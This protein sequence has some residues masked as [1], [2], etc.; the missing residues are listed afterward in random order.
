MLS[1]MFNGA[2]GNMLS[3]S[4]P[5]TPATA[6]PPAPVSPANSNRSS[7]ASPVRLQ[8]QTNSAQRHS[9]GRPATLAPPSRADTPKQSNGSDADRRAAISPSA[10]TD[11]GMLLSPAARFRPDAELIAGSGLAWSA[12]PNDALLDAYAAHLWRLVQSAQAHGRERHGRQARRKQM[13]ELCR[14]VRTFQLPDLRVICDLLSALLAPAN[15]DERSSGVGGGSDEQH[16]CMELLC[17]CLEHQASARACRPFFFH[18]L[19]QSRNSLPSRLHGISLLTRNGRECAPFAVSAGVETSE[20]AAQF[21][22]IH[23][24]Q[25]WPCGACT[26]SHE[27]PSPRI[28]PYVVTP[29]R[30]PSC[31]FLQSSMAA[32]LGQWVQELESIHTQATAHS[33]AVAAASN[34]SSPSSA[35]A[36]AAAAV[37]SFHLSA[38][39]ASVLALPP[40]AADSSV[41]SFLQLE[42]HDPP[43]AVHRATTSKLLLLLMRFV[44]YNRGSMG[45][46]NFSNLV[47]RVSEKAAAESDQVVQS[48]LLPF[49][50]IAI[51]AGL[52][53]TVRPRVVHALCLCE[54]S[55]VARRTLAA[56]RIRCAP[57]L[58]RNAPPPH[59]FHSFCA[60]ACL[61]FVQV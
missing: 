23:E 53:P 41:L 4:K 42:A 8:S 38:A 28:A 13:D 50:D 46:A 27:P 17:L 61:L 37:S 39:G 31:L 33:A 59:Y 19:T 32:V 14:L 35:A 22:T 54:W 3:G 40:A 25:G 11:T 52:T 16:Q 20:R 1:Q 29:A 44:Q 30:L 48:L 6:A 9:G 5:T 12:P 36:A 58:P 57:R 56:T 55:A 15:S 47:H 60:F 45:E 18:V 49:L 51:R 21:L 7:A 43:L 26:C 24:P 10:H 2:V 34:L